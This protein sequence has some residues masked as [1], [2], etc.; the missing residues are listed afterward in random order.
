MCEANGWKF[1][2]SSEALK[3]EKTGF[4]KTSYTIS[5]GLHLSKDGC[6]A[7]FDYIRT[8]AYESTDR[9]PK[10]LSK[11]PERAE[12]PPDLIT[13]DPLKSANASSSSKIDVTFTATE[14][15]T[16]T[17]STEQSVRPGANCTAVTAVPAEGYVFSGWSCTSGR[18]DDTAAAELTF[19]VPSD[20]N[21]FGGIVVTAT[22][23]PVAQYTV[24]FK[25]SNAAGATLGAENADAVSINV[26]SGGTAGTYITLNAG[27]TAVLDKASQDAGAELKDGK[28]TVTN[29]TQEMNIVIVVT[30]AATPTPA[31]TAVPAT[32]APASPS[33]SPSPT[34]EPA[35]SVPTAEPAS[36]AASAVTAPSASPDP[37]AQGS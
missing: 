14:G 12:T 11:V 8:H 26:K 15:G 9:R 21:A 28:V 25:V 13:S 32:Q 5:D 23:E 7:L 29:V 37:G 33:P 2:N 16:L 30:A 27:Y 35:S 10:P 4:A 24:T 36:S 22:F 6:T 1:L 19:T 3:D 20:S 34:P 18:I 31:A 17:G